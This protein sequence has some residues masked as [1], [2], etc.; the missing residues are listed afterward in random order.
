RYGWPEDAKFLV[1]DGVREHFQAGIGARGAALHREWWAMFERY[2]AQYPELAE[3]GYCMM[4]R[5]LPDGWD[6]G[7]PVFPADEKGVATREAWGKALP[8]AGARAPVLG[9]GCAD[10]GRSRRAP[11]P[12]E[13]GG[14]SG[15]ESPAGRNLPFGLRERAMGAV[16]N[17]L[18]L[19]KIRPYGSGFL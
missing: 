17:G 3:N 16:L 8:P 18:S 14:A 13:G 19:S 1:P 2:R 9:R 7:L 5:E 12:F 11:L 6:R 10:R 15:A 4:R